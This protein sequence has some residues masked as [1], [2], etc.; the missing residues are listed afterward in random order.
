MAFTVEIKEGKENVDKEENGA[1]EKEN[2]KREEKGRRE[3]ETASMKGGKE[4]WDSK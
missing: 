3:R 4:E 1:D 2:G